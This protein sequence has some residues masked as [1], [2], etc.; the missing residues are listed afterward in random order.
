MFNRK[1]KYYYG[2]GTD[3][4]LKLKPSHVK[5]F[6]RFNEALLGCTLDQL[7]NGVPLEISRISRKDLERA[8]KVVDILNGYLKNHTVFNSDPS[9]PVLRRVR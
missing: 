4:I 8:N 3:H 9:K 5:S 2:D 1:V 7:L 6:L